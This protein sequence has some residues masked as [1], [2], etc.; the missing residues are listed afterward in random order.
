MRIGLVCYHV[1]LLWMLMPVQATPFMDRTNYGRRN[2]PVQP[3]LKTLM[4]A[5]SA[6]VVWQ[7]E[8]GVF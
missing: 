7:K 3:S 1:S 8:K 6:S 2:C 4:M 5:D